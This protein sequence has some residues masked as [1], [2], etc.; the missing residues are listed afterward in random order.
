MPDLEEEVLGR[1]VRVVYCGNVQDIFGTCI[2]VDFDAR[3]LCLCHV[4][5]LVQEV[6]KFIV[7]LDNPNI[8]GF[9]VL[10]AE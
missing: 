1:R 9:F 6:G 8:C 2:S 10:D 5:G 7:M 4:E 3:I